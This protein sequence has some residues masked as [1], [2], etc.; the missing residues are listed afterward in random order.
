MQEIVQGM[1]VVSTQGRDKDKVYIVKSVDNGYAFVVD[2]K[3]RSLACPKKKKFKHLTSKGQVIES[4]QEKLESNSKI[5][6]SEIRK[7]IDNLSII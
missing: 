2:G 5:L 7:T 6:D 3:Q 1:V 4:I